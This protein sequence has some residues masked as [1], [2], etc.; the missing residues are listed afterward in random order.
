MSRRSST[1]SLFLDSCRNRELGGAR[2]LLLP[3]DAV[4]L[5]GSQSC[6]GI[7][8]LLIGASIP[9]TVRRSKPPCPYHR[10][11]PVA[12]ARVFL[13]RLSLNKV[14]TLSF[15][16]QKL[17]PRCS[18]PHASR[19]RP[20]WWHPFVQTLGG[21]FSALRSCSRFGSRL[22]FAS[23]TLG[24]FKIPALLARVRSPDSIRGISYRGNAGAH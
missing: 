5:P 4:L 15:R 3:F 11:P 12:I 6:A 9:P 22:S 2:P 14:L 18:E 13:S 1:S 17:F 8:D 24:C 7:A 21:V 16:P 23:P 10:T 19:F 20:C